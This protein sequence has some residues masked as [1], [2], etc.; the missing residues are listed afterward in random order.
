[1]S[2]STIGDNTKLARVLAHELVHLYTKQIT[3]Q[4]QKY[5]LS[6]DS[7]HYKW[8]TG[9]RELYEIAKNHPYTADLIGMGHLSE[10]MF[11]DITE[12]IAHA[13]TDARLQGLLEA[14]PMTSAKKSVWQRIIDFVKAL[15]SKKKSRTALT[16]L[17][18][19]S[20]PRLD[21]ETTKSLPYSNFYITSLEEARQSKDDKSLITTSAFGQRP[22]ESEGEGP[23]GLDLLD[24]MMSGQFFSN[25]NKPQYLDTIMSE[26]NKLSP[27]LKEDESAYVDSSNREYRRL[28]NLTQTAFTTSKMTD[29]LAEV[30]AENDFR[31][32]G[33][34][35][36]EIINVR[37]ESF[38][39]NGRVLF[40]E[41][42]FNTGKSKGR[43]AHGLI[44]FL[45]EKDEARR[46]QIGTGMAQEAAA[47]KD[48]Q[49]RIVKEA[50]AP[51]TFK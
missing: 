51:T 26:L 25:P 45:L 14:I 6:P 16:S 22:S 36:G 42:A 31:N 28:T 18:N 13:L 29:N 39:F 3:E 20:I 33:K 9:L 23:K 47:K 40:Y 32:Q 5:E 34:G 10:Y 35:R 21:Y 11:S 8:F 2:L 27:R 12:F 15:F 17:M 30:L 19:L 7:P 38:D 49:G 41:R 43:Y 50:F 37:G 46:K 44:E 24:S 48:D 4:G 1:M